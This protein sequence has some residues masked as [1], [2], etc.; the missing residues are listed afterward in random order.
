MLHVLQIFLKTFRLF[1]ELYNSQ[2]QLINVISKVT[3]EHSNNAHVNCI[4]KPNSDYQH[5]KF[6]RWP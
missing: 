3:D 6:L 1:W 5:I 4:V 2:E